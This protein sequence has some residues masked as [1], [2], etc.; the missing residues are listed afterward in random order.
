MKHRCPEEPNL[1]CFAALA[2]AA[3]QLREM[4]T[5]AKA[6]EE[7]PPNR[8]AAA[9]KPI[10]AIPLKSPPWN[11]WLRLARQGDDNAKLLFC[12]QAEPFIKNFC[13]VAMYTER[14]GKDDVR[15]IAALA[16]V[17]F[18][19]EYADPPEDKEIPFM[20]KRII[21][22]KLTD[23]LRKMSVREQYNYQ[24][25]Q[26]DCDDTE[27]EQDDV[28]EVPSDK[29]EEPEA[30]ALHRELA[31][32]TAVAFQHL[33]PHE[34]QVLDAVFY[35]KKASADIAKEWHCTRQYVEKL[36]DKALRQLRR[37]LGGTRAAYRYPVMG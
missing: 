21:R 12:S 27:P 7:T 6:P 26:R 19:M 35:Q 18:L 31:W 24:K 36:R 14:L 16:V 30:R 17:E 34:Q 10:Q 23:Q 4:R 25:P 15:G 5:D 1:F 13:N 37:L 33:K 9:V 3:Q 8:Y 11:E 22:N 32:D 29:K 2:Y 28:A 20:L